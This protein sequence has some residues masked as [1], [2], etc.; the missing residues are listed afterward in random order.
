ME[1]I[2]LSKVYRIM[3]V[4]ISRINLELQNSARVSSIVLCK[5][6]ENKSNIYK[7]ILD[8]KIFFQWINISLFFS[9]SKQEP[10]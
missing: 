2:L 8:K 7:V 4:Q 1:V 9:V 6:Q 3:Q 10:S 5:L